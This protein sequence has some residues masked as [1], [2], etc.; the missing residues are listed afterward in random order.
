MSI[1]DLLAFFCPNFSACWPFGVPVKQAEK[2]GQKN[3]SKK[4]AFPLLFGEEKMREKT[5][6][7]HGTISTGIRAIA[8][9]IVS[10]PSIFGRPYM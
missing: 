1:E 10:R 4:I 5:V 3:V 2:L 8:P 7:D 6:R 9:V